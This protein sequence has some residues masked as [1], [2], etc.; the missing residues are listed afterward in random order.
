MDSFARIGGDHNPLHRCV[1]AARLAGLPRPIVHGA[2][3][4]ARALAF[5]VDEV[6][7]GDA[8]ALQRWRMSFVAPI[9]LGAELELAAA[10]VALQDGRE[11]VEVTVLADGELAATGEALVA[12]PRTVLTFCGQGVQRRGLGADGRARSRAAHAVWARADACTRSR[13]GFS[14]LDVVERNPTELR[15]ADGRVLRHPDGVLARTE[16][17]QPALVTLH[18]AQLA[19][20]REAGALG[21]RR[22]PRR[23]SQRRRVLGARGARG[24]RARDGARARVRARRAH[25][26]ARRA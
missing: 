11:V 23:R 7:A 21:R 5:V 26:G 1:L 20:L 19:E 8:A 12:P 18:A 9:A 10:R 22:R 13:L 3:T 25:A 2:W 17:T 6:C 14:L 24:A 15:L 4:A 16:L